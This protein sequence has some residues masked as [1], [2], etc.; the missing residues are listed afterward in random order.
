[1]VTV[2]RGSRS[3]HSASEWI[4]HSTICGFTHIALHHLSA[5]VP[6]LARDVL[7]GDAVGVDITALEGARITRGALLIGDRGA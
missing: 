5:P 7:S 1:M 4:F 2:L 3:A 6:G